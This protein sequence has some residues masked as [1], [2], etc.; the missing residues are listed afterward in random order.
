MCMTKSWLFRGPSDRQA[1]A[2]GVGR[3]QQ[4]SQ[5]AG[6]EGQ[7][8]EETVAVWGAGGHAEDGVGR[9]PGGVSPVGGRPV[10]EVPPAPDRRAVDEVPQ[11]QQVQPGRVPRREPLHGRRLQSQPRR[12]QHLRQDPLQRGQARRLETLRM[13]QSVKTLHTFLLHTPFF[14]FFCP[15]GV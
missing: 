11:Q 1:E 4:T 15:R 8:P 9:V 7:R 13:S 12:R 2:T 3:A 5:Q 14:L 6:H 10:Q